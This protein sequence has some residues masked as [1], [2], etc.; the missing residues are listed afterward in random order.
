M[1]R[2]HHI[3]CFANDWESDPLSK[4]H[5]MKRLAEHNR[6]LWVNSLGYRRPRPSAR[7]FRRAAEK[8]RRIARGLR[9]VAPNLWV[10]SPFVLPFHGNAAARR[11][12]QRF[13]QHTLLRTVRRLHMEDPI[14]WT[15][16]PSSAD[17]VGSLGERLTL[18][19]CV[20]EFS[21]RPGADGAAIVAMEKKLLERVDLVLVSAGPLEEAKRRFNPATHLVTHG[22]DVEHF[23]RALDAA[24]RVPPELE[25][26]PGPV[27]GFFGLVADWVD[28]DLVRKVAQQRPH[29]SI[30]LVGKVDTDTSAIAGL[31]N[32]HVMGW[33]DYA[34]LPGWCKGFD[35]A[36]LPF[37]V[38]KL[39]LAANP[40]KLREYLAAGL[41]VVATALPEAERLAPWVRVGYNHDHFLH[42]LD[43]VVESGQ[44]GPSALR[45]AAMEKES[46]DAKV[47]AMSEIVDG[48]LERPA[49]R[50]AHA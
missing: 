19:H 3:V 20:A 48:Y 44:L 22:V 6:V 14:T 35:A 40:L 13:L 49:A 10:W 33:R 8:L 26:L 32:V 15:F 50:R 39:T 42:Q 5:I 2:G 27:I 9:R 16:E 21:E 12:N 43:A 45:S 11:W 1:L 18:Y 30:V 17:V 38:N 34:S 36:I 46:W 37:R 41:P 47:E 24:T 23:G 4:K 28:L 7:D 25:R 29:W 31:A